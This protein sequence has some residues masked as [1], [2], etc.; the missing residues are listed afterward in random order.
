[1]KIHISDVID[2]EL[3]IANLMLWTASG[4]PLTKERVAAMTKQSFESVWPCYEKAVRYADSI[5]HRID[6]DSDDFKFLFSRIQIG[7]SN[8]SVSLAHFCFDYKRDE[9]E[10]VYAFL[11]YLFEDD[12]IIDSAS[13]VAYLNK[14]DFSDYE[15]YRILV[16]I[17]NEAYVRDLYDA[18]KR[19]HQDVYEALDTFYHEDAQEFARTF[20]YESMIQFLHDNGVVFDMETSFE[21]CYISMLA[22]EPSRIEL[23]T[24]GQ[25]TSVAIRI[26]Q[27]SMKLKSLIDTAEIAVDRFM[28]LMK[29]LGDPTKI[30]ILRFCNDDAHYGAE[31]AKHLGITGATVS[32]HM[33]EL[34]ARN[35]VS[36]DVD[37]NKAYYKTNLTR[38]LD[39][40]GNAEEALKSSVN[41][42]DWTVGK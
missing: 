33:S 28:T 36:V 42:R 41:L 34:L 27:H 29:V 16:F 1:M 5:A 25:D 39:H 18:W 7:T 31:I 19:E 23:R 35:Y 6:T 32:H 14:N 13:M 22:L 26:G 12:S 8:V 4:E 30:E 21:D 9:F 3:E 11:N 15:R 10:S 37:K 20:D 38:I 17:M 24:K 2:T 40:L